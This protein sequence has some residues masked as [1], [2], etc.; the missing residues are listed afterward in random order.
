VLVVLDAISTY[1][2]LHR[3]PPEMEFNP[4][5]RHLLLA[6]GPW[7]LIAYAPVEYAVVL[8]L[9]ELLDRIYRRLGMRPEKYVRVALMLLYV[10]I[11]L[12]WLGVLSS[13]HP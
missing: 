7:I 8:L 9:L 3:Y 5:L 13:S 12:N 6:C 10:P 4:I 11:L 2:L 1:L